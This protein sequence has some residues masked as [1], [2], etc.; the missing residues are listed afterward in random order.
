MLNQRDAETTGLLITKVSKFAQ[1]SGLMAG[2]IIV[3]ANGKLMKSAS[4][5]REACRSDQVLLLVQRD[6]GRI[7]IP[8][9]FPKK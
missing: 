6:G 5:L 4:D 8:V 2:D 1:Q 3:S 9:R 7:F